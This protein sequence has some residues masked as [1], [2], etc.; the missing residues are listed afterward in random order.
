MDE[1]RKNAEKSDRL[2][3]GC[4]VLLFVFLLLLCLATAAWELLLPRF[5]ERTLLPQ[6]AQQYGITLSAGVRSFGITGADF[7]DVEVRFS[8]R[9]PL[10]IDSLR[11]DYN[12]MPRRPWLRIS[13]LTVSGLDISVEQTDQGQ[14]LLNGYSVSPGASG[15]TPDTSAAPAAATPLPEP[16]DWLELLE[17]RNGHIRLQLPERT[18]VT[19]PF[20]AELRN[21][22][23]LNLT[24]R[25]EGQLLDTEL[26]Y[27]P[28]LQCLNFLFSGSV[29]PSLLPG[30]P[31]PAGKLRLTGQGT[32]HLM[33]VPEKRLTADVEAAW[34]TNWLATV[35]VS[36]N[37]I[38]A[39]WES[40]TGRWSIALRGELALP[41]IAPSPTFELTPGILHYQ[42]TA[43]GATGEPPRLSGNL[44]WTPFALRSGEMQLRIPEIRL[45]GDGQ[46]PWNLQTSLYLH[47]PGLPD[48]TFGR[49]QAESIPDGIR[50]TL[51]ELSCGNTALG[52]AENELTV[53]NG[54]LR[55]TGVY[56]AS[57]LPG[58]QLRWN[59]RLALDASGN[60]ELTLDLPPWRSPEPINPGRYAP[61][62]GD[63]FRVN[64]TISAG[65]RLSMKN[66]QITSGGSLMLRDAT[67]EAPEMGLSV[68]GGQAEIQ[69][70]DLLRL[71]TRPAQ[72]LTLDETR[73][74]DLTL[75]KVRV[76]FQ[77]HNPQDLLVES[78]ET[79]WC[80]GNIH[81]QATRL[82]SGR[83][84]LSTMIYC[85]GVSL[86]QALREL[87]VAQTEGEGKL[88]GK[89]PVKLRRSGI[90]FENAY[91]YSEPGTSGII[92]L[93]NAGE[94]LAM[95]GAANLSELDLASEALKNFSYEWAKL[96]FDTTAG[97]L[98]LHLQF[99]GKPLEPLPFTLDPAT[100]RLVRSNQGKA[101]FQGLRL[102]VNLTLPLNRL[103]RFNERL[104][105]LRSQQP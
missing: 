68:N 20:E 16:P 84:N 72:M 29:S 23:R 90:F 92:R 67:A 28:R 58:L 19:V 4:L 54:E 102:N 55:M 5:L 40:E 99:D 42:G 6:L 15:K 52:D 105:Q 89:I 34:E 56:R 96:N 62:L 57:T 1:P 60:G 11:L 33:E 9:K 66:F 3:K 8:E 13:R 79:N 18:A 39:D 103:L 59:A 76:A 45:T 88:T 75:R 14:W 71:Q 43:A 25:P 61:K 24:L 17:F 49:I 50:M 53:K 104:N 86:S 51:Q 21:G 70:A 35:P 100:S 78:A 41:R 10:K 94:L 22:T 30:L 80:G 101:T 98:A 27:D 85:D 63:G 73:I 74:G 69:F 47:L 91:L 81:L 36:R 83:S 31:P 65:L 2:K 38:T 87:G 32:F 48:F 77:L 97:D 64:G 37:R 7:S 95:A 46:S 26:T 82:R 44:N 93:R 12:F